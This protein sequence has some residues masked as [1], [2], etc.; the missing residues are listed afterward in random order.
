MNSLCSCTLPHFFFFWLTYEIT[1][2][3][4]LAAGASSGHHQVHPRCTGG[5]GGRSCQAWQGEKCVDFFLLPITRLKQHGGKKTL[6]GS[7][8]N[9]LLQIT[10]ELS[11]MKPQVGIDVTSLF[12]IFKTNSFVV[13]RGDC[14]CPD[15]SDWEDGRDELKHIMQGCVTVTEFFLSRCHQFPLLKHFKNKTSVRKT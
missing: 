5:G 7:S 6:F 9:F 1:P 3:A 14:C 4:I 11:E 12:N 15:G 8:L 2:S 13:C 10:S